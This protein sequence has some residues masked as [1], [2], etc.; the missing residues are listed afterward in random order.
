MPLIEIT[1]DF[2]IESFIAP[3]VAI[4]ASGVVITTFTLTK[5]GHFIA[6]GANMH[7]Q[8]GSA[9]A[10]SLLTVVVRRTDNNQLRFGDSITQIRAVRQNADVIARNLGMQCVVYMAS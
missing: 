6:V 7:H 3:Q 1:K 9:V 5:P 2:W 10:S 8:I 4:P